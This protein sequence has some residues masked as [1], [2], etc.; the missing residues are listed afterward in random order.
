[1]INAIA[2]TKITDTDYLNKYDCGLKYLPN[3]KKIN[4]LLGENNSSKSRLIR[5]LIKL[6]S[7][8]LS[9]DNILDD[10]RNTVNSYRTSIIKN[11]D[12][13][14]KTSKDISKIEIKIPEN[15]KL[16]NDTE[17]FVT[18][19]DELEHKIKAPEKL[20]NYG[21]KNYYNNIKTYLDYLF[22][23]L[24]RVNGNRDMQISSFNPIYIPI[25]RGIESFDLYYDLKKSSILG[26]I[27]LTEEQ[28]QAMDEYKENAKHIYRNKIAKAYKIPTKTIFT[29]EDLYDEVVSKLLGEEKERTFIV[30]FQNFI[31]ENFF[32]GNY[33]QIL[34]RQKEKILYVKI[35]D[36][37]EKPIHELGDGIKQII[38]IFYKIFEFRDEERIFF[39]EEP[40]INLHPGLQRKLLE[41][42]L[43]SSFDKH[44][45]FITTH[46]NHLIDSCFEFEDISLYKFINLNNS[47]SIFK[48]I[49]T[50]YKDV[51]MLQLLGVNNT[52]VFM[53]NCTIW[54]EG[55]SDRILIKKYLDVYFKEHKINKYKEDINYSFVE[56]GGNNITHWSFIDNDEIETINASGITNRCFLICDNDNG[57]KSER[58]QKLKEIFKENM[59]E[60][61]VREIENTI[62]KTVLEKTL[63]VDGNIKYLNEGYEGEVYANSETYM[64]TFIDEHYELKKR[65]SNGGSGTILNKLEFSK[66]ISENINNYEDLSEEAITIC[67]SIYEFVKRS[68][69]T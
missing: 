17:F 66:K 46:S 54:I 50:T 53:S 18:I 10:K 4:I 32:N 30:E 62:S 47:N 29:A 41:T 28:R 57:A 37:K 19:N 34:P 69:N 39:I 40:E 31:S 2:T 36:S 45:F 22:N 9:N 67:E 68:N 58:K 59:Y 25:L 11:I 15:Y 55:I 43:Q 24:C 3:I 5:Y 1:M 35:G 26:K 56:Y 63:F 23:A 49:N 65:Y 8:V 38:T 42:L 61:N 21:E 44:Q 7:Q 33:F 64:G 6:D 60:L 52:S 48:V 51:E 27:N 16:L 14:N 13:F 20:S 12:N